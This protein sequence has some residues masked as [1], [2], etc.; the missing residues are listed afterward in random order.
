VFVKV[1]ELGYKVFHMAVRPAEMIRLDLR[2]EVLSKASGSI[3]I[4]VEPIEQRA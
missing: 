2:K 1:P 4:E 3:T